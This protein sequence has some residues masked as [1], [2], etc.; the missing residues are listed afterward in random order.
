LLKLLSTTQRISSFG[1]IAASVS[2]GYKA[3]AT[4]GL[5]SGCRAKGSSVLSNIEQEW[6]E[7]YREALLASSRTKESRFRRVVTAIAR[8]V[9]SPFRKAAVQTP[10]ISQKQR[11][12]PTKIS[13]DKIPTSQPQRKKKKAS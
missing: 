5:I 8:A 2:A 3:E 10:S 1:G 7:K 4:V 9:A 6:I 12:T 11:Q 13:S